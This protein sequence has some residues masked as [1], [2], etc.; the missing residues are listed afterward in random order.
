MSFRDVICRYQLERVAEDGLVHTVRTGLT[1]T[2]AKRAKSVWLSL[3]SEE[4]FETEMWRI[5]VRVGEKRVV[6]P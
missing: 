6:L 1:L 4:E 2:A 5:V 3:R